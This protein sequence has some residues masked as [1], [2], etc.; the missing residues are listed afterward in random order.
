MLQHRLIP[1]LSK[2][3]I[4][5]RCFPLS[6]WHCTPRLF[7]AEPDRRAVPSVVHVLHSIQHQ[8]QA[9]FAPGAAALD[10]R[11][12]QLGDRGRDGPRVLGRQSRAVAEGQPRGA[13]KRRLALKGS[14][15]KTL[16]RCC[17]NSKTTILRLLHG[18]HHP[19]RRDGQ[20]T[21][22]RLQSRSPVH[23]DVACR[24]PCGVAE[25]GLLMRRLP[26]LV[27]GRYRA[28]CR[29]QQAAPCGSVANVQY[30]LDS[31]GQRSGEHE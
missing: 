28:R 15:T 30:V 20:Q 31:L 5:S 10:L 29:F 13:S 26:E 3:L 8:Q 23:C 2:T 6:C 9:G 12:A 18:H 7:H 21:P 14:P 4:S 1:R 25:S 17:L 19:F 27:A 11:G 22:P 24:Y 16:P